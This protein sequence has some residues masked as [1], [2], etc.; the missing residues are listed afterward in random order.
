M[1]DDKKVL[2][3]RSEF[4]DIV[5]ED[6]FCSKFHCLLMLYSDGAEPAIGSVNEVGQFNFD[7]TFC[8]IKDTSIEKMMQK[9]EQLITHDHPELAEFDDITAIGLEIL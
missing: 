7:K 8:R 2:I 9:F 3:G 1:F 5:I 4:A 6:E